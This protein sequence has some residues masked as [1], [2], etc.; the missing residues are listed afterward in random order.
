MKGETLKLS[1]DRRLLILPGDL[2]ALGYDPDIFSISRAVRMSMS[3]PFFFEPVKL[4]DMNG[5]VHYL[6]ECGKGNQDRGL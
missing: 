5:R 2:A 1:T 4:Q 3:I 6:E